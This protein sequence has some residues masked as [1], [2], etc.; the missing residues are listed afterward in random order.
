V[1][2]AG[3]GVLMLAKIFTIEDLRGQGE[4]LSTL[5]WFSVLF[6]LSFYLSELGFMGYIGALIAS[7]LE[8]MDWPLVYVILIVS[9]V[10]VHYLFV[11]QTAQMLALFG[12]YLQVGI[13]AG[14]PAE[15][16]A[17]MLLFATNFNSAITPQG[18]SANVIFA[19][20]EYMSAGEIYRNGLV[21]TLMNLAVFLG[22]GTFWILFIS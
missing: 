10:L 11:S 18:S 15:L 17:L 16:L 4:A 3:L 7:G 1:A 12:V 13:D 8:G 21:M 14:V 22:I 19:S 6:T 9:Y 20:S 5:I 2:F